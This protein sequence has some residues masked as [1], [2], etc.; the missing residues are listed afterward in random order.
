M[1][2]SEGDEELTQDYEQPPCELQEVD[3]NCLSV[4]SDLHVVLN[5]KIGGGGQAKVYKC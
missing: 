4:F 2:E 3:E 5:E 1:N